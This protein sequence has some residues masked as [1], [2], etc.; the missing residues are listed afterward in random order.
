MNNLLM[1]CI[2]NFHIYISFKW[3]DYCKFLSSRIH[4]TFKILIFCMDFFISHMFK[5]IRRLAY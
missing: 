5:D 4:F 3:D 1:K 2:Q